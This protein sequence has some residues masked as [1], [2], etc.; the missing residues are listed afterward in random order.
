MIQESLQKT[1]ELETDLQKIIKLEYYITEQYDPYSK[2]VYGILIRK[3]SNLYNMLEFEEDSAHNL[4]YS[5]EE[6][7][8]ICQILIKNEVTPISL[9]YIL[10]DMF[11]HV[12]Q[13]YS[14]IYK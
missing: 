9:S 2:I 8:T 10:E 5:Y 7:D 13:E 6:V 3:Y 4:T 14:L 11:N 12:P 1:I